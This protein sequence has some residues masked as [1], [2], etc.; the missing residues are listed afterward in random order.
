MLQAVIMTGLPFLAINGQSAFR[1]DI[2]TLKLYFFG[3]VIWMR[4]FY[5][6]LAATL[7]FCSSSAL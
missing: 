4:E 5:L 7:F 3:S 2:P 1:F 6:I